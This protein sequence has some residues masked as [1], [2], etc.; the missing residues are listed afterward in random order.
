MTIAVT[1]L[2]IGVLVPVL[3]ASGSKT[4]DVRDQL[5]LKVFLFDDASNGEI[6][7]LQDKISAIPHVET[8]S[9]SPRRR[10]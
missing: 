8:S 4:D 9:T 1:V 3:D 7:S 2:L 10:R 5:E 6:S